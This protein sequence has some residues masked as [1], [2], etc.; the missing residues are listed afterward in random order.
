MP[1]FLGGGGLSDASAFF[2]SHCS[3]SPSTAPPQEHCC[4]A[5][6]CVRGRT[7]RPVRLEPD[8]CGGG[9]K[10]CPVYVRASRTCPR[11]HLWG[12][13]VL[14]MGSCTFRPYIRVVP[15]RIVPVVSFGARDNDRRTRGWK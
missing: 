5:R 13:G 4:M 12:G 15:P 6:S 3:R 9:R 11:I 14:Y 1:L 7:S 8:K 10:Q 2:F